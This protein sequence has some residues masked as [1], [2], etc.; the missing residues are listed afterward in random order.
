MHLYANPAWTFKGKHQKK[1]SFSPPGP[2]TYDPSLKTISKYSAAPT[3]KIGTSSRDHLVPSLVPG[4]GTYSSG[5]IRPHSSAPVIGT[6]KRPELS[7]NANPGP[8]AYE[9]ISKAT[10]GPKY[11]MLGKKPENNSSNSPGPGHYAPDLND[12]TSKERAPTYRIGSAERTERTDAENVPGPGTYETGGREA[13]PKWGFGSESREKLLKEEVPGPGTYQI[14]N[15]L[16]NPSY[17]MA[18][19]KADKKPDNFPG[20]GTY[21]PS[22]HTISKYSA[23][24]TCKIGTSTRDGF[25]FNEVP[26]PGTY[27]AGEIRP[28][29]S[30]PVIGTSKRPDLNPNSNPGPGTYEVI[31]KDVEGP[32]Y[33][34]VGRKNENN[35][36]NSPGPGHY[37][38]ELN[39]FTSRERAPTYRIGSAARTERNNTE[40]VPGPGT[41]ETS[42]KEVGPKWGFGTE[43]RDKLFKEEV[44]GPGTYQISNALNNPSYTMA[45]RKSDKKPDNFPGPG[46]YDPLLNTI[47][48]YSA[49]PTCKIGTSTREGFGFNEV[50]GPGTYSAGEIRPHSSAP[51]IGTSKRPDLNPSSNPGPGTYEV[52]PKDSEGPKYTMVGRKNEPHSSTS[53]GP[54]HYEPELN[55]FTSKERAPTYRIGSA[56]RSDRPGAENVPGPGSYNPSGKEAGPKWAFGTESRDKLIPDQVPGPGAYQ[57]PNAQTQPS[58]SMP[59]R[60]SEKKPDNFPG[61]GA[62]DPSLNA[63]SKYSAAPTC[64]MGKSSREAFGFNEVPGPGTYSAGAIRPHSSAPLI[65]TSKRPDLA[66]NRNPGP[67]TYEVSPQTGE[68]PQFTMPGK[69]IQ[70]AAEHSP[71]PGHYNPELNDFTST[72]RAPTFR[73]G[74]ASRSSRPST[75]TV[76]GPGTYDTRGKEAGPRWGFG[77]ESREKLLKEE[78]PGPGAYQIPNTLAK[79]SYSLT[80]R[81]KEK[82]KDNFPGPGSYNV[83]D[84]PKSPSWSMGKTARLDFGSPPE[85]PGPGAYSPKSGLDRHG[86]V[87]GT[88][89]RPPLSMTNK[90][91][92]PGEYEGPHVVDTPAYTMRPRTGT[93]KINNVP[94]PGQYDP[95]SSQGEP[96]WTV[97][98]EKKGS[99][100]TLAKSASLP[101]PGM[102]DTRKGLGGPKWSFGTQAKSKELKAPIPG[103]GQYDFYS[104]I[105]NLPTYA[106]PKV[107]T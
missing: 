95:K 38:P 32:K 19:R 77:T 67:G 35:S 78:A 63:I 92:G 52:I 46:A 15:A 104:S 98:K 60:K 76:P 43:S 9:V 11:T 17:S 34:M 24:P 3:C 2:G 106:A 72:E 36:P 64:K 86:V 33:T 14:P 21:E 47:S 48:K 69:G 50:P 75:A 13:G 28:H 8:G 18:G 53:P 105:S 83:T 58:Y 25:G 103:P 44:P 97:G 56:A 26:G 85:V 101:G 51:V 66:P 81:K 6:S 87:F 45:G 99:E 71:G 94:G 62:Y 39:D 4:P 82:K 30:A 59:G 102:Y 68:G 23:A 10:E 80:G 55:D 5:A 61:P 74:K 40:H 31:P 84:R 37:E 22:L 16:S 7:A 1:R 57:I 42:G 93:K 100:H 27:S 65:G 107:R 49:A 41:Y 90:N 73:I 89:N 29:S 12:F 20:P 79:T 88:S 91:P 96:R 54:G 70:I